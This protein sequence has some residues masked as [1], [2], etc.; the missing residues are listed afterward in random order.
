[1]K[2][3]KAAL[4]RGRAWHELVHGAWRGEGGSSGYAQSEQPIEGQMVRIYANHLREVLDKLEGFAILVRQSNDGLAA[5]I[6]W[7]YC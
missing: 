6:K 1:M 4:P 7:R 5:G 3:G 2:P